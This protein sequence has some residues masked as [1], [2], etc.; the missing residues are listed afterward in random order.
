VIQP[1]FHEADEGLLN[2]FAP[3]IANDLADDNRCRLKWEVVLNPL[4]HL[5]DRAMQA[6]SFDT[7]RFFPAAILCAALVLLPAGVSAQQ[8]LTTTDT[9][10]QGA[11]GNL[12][13]TAY[14]HERVRE[15]TRA[16]DAKEKGTGRAHTLD[17]TYTYGLT[18]TLDIY[19]GVS[20]ARLRARAKGFEEGVFI[21]S[22]K[23]SASGFGNTTIGA[24]WRFFDN[25]ESGTS[26]AINPEIALPVSS[27]RQ[28]D[29]LGSGRTSGSL[30]FVLSQSLP[31]GSLNFN[32]G[33]GRDRNRHED[34]TRIRSFSVAP[35]WEISE[36]W[37]LAFDTGFERSR[38]DGTTE[39]SRFSEIT[40]VYAPVE[41]VEVSIAYTHTR[42]RAATRATDDEPRSKTN[43]KT[44]AVAIGVAWAF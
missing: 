21:G 23:E 11:G 1:V 20:H 41:G 6:L 37:K 17:V 25:E 18:E 32:A 10:T 39:R 24:K 7:S 35:V 2:F 27:Q 30:T 19:A 9:G 4:F 14:S 33:I 28:E 42:T 31:F 40:A 12:I 15:R 36:Q 26:L 13:E 22:D 8:L 38:Q 3:D 29:E 44:N 16:E 43:G 5:E 34:S